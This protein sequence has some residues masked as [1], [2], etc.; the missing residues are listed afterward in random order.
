MNSIKFEDGQQSEIILSDRHKRGDKD[1]FGCWEYNKL[2]ECGG[3]LHSELVDE[4]FA[5]EDYDEILICEYRCDK[6]NKE[7]PS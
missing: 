3:I 2:C 7:I 6:C 1:C 4:V 5:G